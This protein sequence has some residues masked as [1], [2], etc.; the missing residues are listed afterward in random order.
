MNL[1][2]RA[3]DDW[4]E[5]EVF[6]YPETSGGRKLSQWILSQDRRTYTAVLSQYGRCV[7][8]AV[9]VLYVTADL[10]GKALATVREAVVLAEMELDSLIDGD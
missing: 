9:P 4:D 6:S 3:L 1:V 8:I 10:R 2:E 7:E 5:A